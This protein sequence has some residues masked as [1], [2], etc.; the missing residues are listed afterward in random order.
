LEDEYHYLSSADGNISVPH[1]CV[2]PKTT[3]QE[4]ST[5]W[6]GDALCSGPAPAT[7]GGFPQE[8]DSLA[9]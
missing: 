7:L 4:V 3:K 2:L 5:G 1:L 9:F 8:E 6:Q